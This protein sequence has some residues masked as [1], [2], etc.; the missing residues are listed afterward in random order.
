MLVNNKKIA[1]FGG[2][3]LSYSLGGSAVTNDYLRG[4]GC[5]APVLLHT[6]IGLRP[7][8]VTI[9]FEGEDR[10][11]TIAKISAFA[12]EVQSKSELWLPDGFTYTCIL[13][14]I[15]E[16]VE[17]LPNYQEVSYN[18]DAVQHKELQTVS[19]A[20]GTR[21]EI[22]CTGNLPSRCVVTV[23]PTA[24]LASLTLTFSGKEDNSVTVNNLKANQKF[25]IDGT[26]CTVTLNGV[27]HFQNTNLIDFPRLDPGVNTLLLSGSVPV[28]VS[29]YP[30]YL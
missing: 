30:S 14:S 25:V 20:S 18:F 5:L 17:I 10:E 27:N 12:C 15:S 28:S 7:L 1:E 9:T 4:P 21:H 16:V 13:T 29:F 3:L 11:D 22:F 8:T 24:N 26:A 19:F 2:K 23:T 6:D